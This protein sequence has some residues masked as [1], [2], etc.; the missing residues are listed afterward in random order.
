M[1]TLS[2][3]REDL[4]APWGPG[5]A[6]FRCGRS[7]IAPFAHPA[8][9]AFA[10]EDGRR[11]AIVVRERA[12]AASGED[13][14]P[15]AVHRVSP[16]RY[17]ERLAETV[18]WRLDQVVVEILSAPPRVRIRAG[19][20]GT[21]PLYLTSSVR[22]LHADFHYEALYRHLGSLEIDREMVAHF[23][24]GSHPY[25]RRT[26]LRGVE[27]LTERAEAVWDGALRIRYPQPAAP[28]SPG[29]LREGKDPI[30]AFRALLGAVLERSTRGAA[31]PWGA[32]L[33]GGADSACVA[34]LAAD[35]LGA[36][37]TYGLE[38]VGWAAAHQRARRA[39]LVSLLGA[40]DRT[41]VAADFPPL[42]LNGRRAGAPAFAPFNEIYSEAFDALLELAHADGVRRMLTGIG[43]D[44]LFLPHHAE[45]ALVGEEGPGARA[46]GVTAPDYLAAE[47]E[48]IHRETFYTI[49]HAPRTVVPRSALLSLASRAPVF[50][51]RG[52]WPT[53][54]LVAP[55]L[56][57][58]C[59][60]L[61]LA[62]R[63]RKHLLRQ[64]LLSSGC[65]HSTAYPELH[66]S[67]QPVYTHAMRDTAR[68]LLMRLFRGSRLADLGLLDRNRLL[69]AY[70][71]YAR[72]GVTR[73]DERFYE[74]A[75]V[76]LMLLAADAPLR[77][78]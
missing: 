4:A 33:S 26:L 75:A 40:T 58:L 39:D 27:T 51:R 67:F 31:V 68:L 18:A 37:R 1:L 25:G 46:S 71:D 8:L 73:G 20:W 63:R 49:D 29:R 30:T 61:P 55:E 72:T 11:T 57:G 38:V 41:V 43:G 52:I 9:C 19:A 65:L 15:R 66:E 76:E 24:M 60:R 70:A 35:R 5:G 10:I 14:Q 77:G 23:L 42:S 32:E 48:D 53:S 69:A 13:E 45:L 34:L 7:H 2:I 54:P 21:A 16:E 44:E 74:I 56:V 78:A 59:R 47:V 3:H 36:P 6:A 64:L 50:L 12:E 62:W 17:D 22:V 28:L